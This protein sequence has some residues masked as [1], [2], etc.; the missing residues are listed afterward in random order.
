MKSDSS[1]EVK[2]SDPLVAAAVRARAEEIYEKSGRLPGRDQENWLRGNRKC[3]RRGRN[4]F[5]R[6]WPT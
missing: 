6:Q 3:F 5:G 2:D 4:G 1:H